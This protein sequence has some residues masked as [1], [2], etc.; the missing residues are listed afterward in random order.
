MTSPSADP[1]A[2]LAPASPLLIAARIDSPAGQALSDRAR[3]LMTPD[4]V[5][6]HDRY[7]FER[8]RLE[9]RVTRALVR[10]SL[11]RLLGAEPSALRFEAGSHGKPALV[12]PGAPRLRFN[13]SNTDGLVALLLALDHDAGVDV[14]PRDRRVEARSV[15][16]RFFSPTEVGHLFAL[17]P[18]QHH[19]R[20]LA[21]WT[22]K[23][24]YIKACGLGLAIPLDHFSFLLDSGSSI[25]IA[26]APERDDDPSAWQF[27][28]PPVSDAHLAAVA[29]RRPGADLAV[30]VADASLLV[31]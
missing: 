8:N 4:E 21:Y 15:A 19:E 25:Q 20:F 2:S 7:H 24:A 9:F 13:L 5:A 28:R 1:F 14:E 27:A 18:G 12:S 23:E 10:L 3:S 30:Q 26:F 11:G 22:L 29:L 31:T 16:H 6:R 17:P